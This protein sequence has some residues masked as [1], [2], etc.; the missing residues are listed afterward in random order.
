MKRYYT[1]A[2]SLR[3]NF[4]SLGDYLNEQGIKYDLTVD[5]ITELKKCEFKA[6]PGIFIH[7]DLIKT[8][9]VLLDEHELSA[10][11]LCVDGVQII[12]NRIFED[13]VNHIRYYFKWILK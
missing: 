5:Y 9:I 4:R 11:M 7:T 12:R 1:F 10:I 13:I 8:Y 2:Q 6:G 3:D